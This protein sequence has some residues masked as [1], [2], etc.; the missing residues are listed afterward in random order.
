L[1]RAA[2]DEI[3]VGMKTEIPDSQV[4]NPFKL[5]EDLRRRAPHLWMQ[6]VVKEISP[7]PQAVTIE[8]LLSIRRRWPKFLAT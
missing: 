2:P 5:V 6:A 8:A 7:A 3:L 1:H 4:Q